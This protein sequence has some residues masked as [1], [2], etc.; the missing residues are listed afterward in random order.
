MVWDVSDSTVKDQRAWPASRVDMVSPASLHAYE[1]NPRVHLPAQIEQI[2]ASILAFGF[3]VPV[4]VDENDMLIA[5]HARH[6]AALDLGLPQIPAM[7]ARGW[8][9]DQKRAYVIADNRLASNSGWDEDLLVMEF[10]D[11]ADTP[12]IGLT[13][14]PLS[15]IE[16]L[17]DTGGQGDGTGT[18]DVDGNTLKTVRVICQPDAVEAV[19]KVLEEALSAKGLREVVVKRP[20]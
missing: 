11:L 14:F 5:G 10:G 19:I 16:R 13:G 9:D 7:V 15:E 1:K 4:L 2:K 18:D 3:T 17:R 12:W 6:M 8:S 20:P